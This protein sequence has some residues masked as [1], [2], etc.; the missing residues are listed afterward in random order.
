MISLPRMKKN[1]MAAKIHPFS[2][3]SLP[4]LTNIEHLFWQTNSQ[5]EKGF[6]KSLKK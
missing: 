3:E 2:F 6:Y 5:V 1:N 4:L